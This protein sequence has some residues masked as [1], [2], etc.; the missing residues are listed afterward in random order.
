M[1]AQAALAFAKTGRATAVVLSR[2]GLPFVVSGVR[3]IGQAKSF[4]SWPMIHSFDLSP[5]HWSQW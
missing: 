2:L 3:L 4:N 5:D 1:R